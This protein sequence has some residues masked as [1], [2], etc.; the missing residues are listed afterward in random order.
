MLLTGFYVEE[1]IILED[2]NYPSLLFFS[3]LGDYAKKYRNDHDVMHIGGNN[4]QNSDI[5]DNKS[6]FL[7]FYSLL[8][9]LGNMARFMEKHD[10]DFNEIK[11]FL[12]SKNGRE[13]Q[14]ILIYVIIGF[15]AITMHGSEKLI[16]GLTG[17]AYD[18]S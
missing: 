5:I 9:G 16:A 15:H 14:M 6:L 10:P 7:F 18:S 8:L 12:N 3:V 17:G 2:D 13:Y 1:G 4:F 11:Y